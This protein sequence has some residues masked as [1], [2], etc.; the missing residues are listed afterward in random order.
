MQD[1]LKT[2][3]GIRLVNIS[4][5]KAKIVDALGETWMQLYYRDDDDAWYIS[6]YKGVKAEHLYKILERDI[7]VTQRI[8]NQRWIHCPS[9]LTTQFRARARI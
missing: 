4:A 2:V 3:A 9:R 6:Q 5:T 1:H 7:T 8:Y